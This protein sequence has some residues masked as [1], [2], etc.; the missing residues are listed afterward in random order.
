M[1]KESV[2]EEMKDSEEKQLMTILKDSGKPFVKKAD[3]YAVKMKEDKQIDYKDWEG[4]ERTLKVPEGSYVVCGADSNY[5]KIVTAEDFEEKNK[6]ID[7]PKKKDNPKKEE[8]SKTGM[9]SMED[10]Y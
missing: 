1:I 4:N 10:N 3:G 8:S 5:P 9:A 2:I 6:F 7:G